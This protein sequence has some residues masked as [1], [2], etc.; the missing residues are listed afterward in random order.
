MNNPLTGL[1]LLD[2]L[3]ELKYEDMPNFD[4][5]KACGYVSFKKDGSECVNFGAFYEAM[6]DAKKFLRRATTGDVE[7]KVGIPVT[8]Y[9]NVAVKGDAGL[10]KESIVRLVNKDHLEDNEDRALWKSI[11]A[12]FYT[13]VVNPWVSG[14]IDSCRVEEIESGAQVS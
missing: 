12:A 13:K 8:V 7:Y 14:Y 5:V 9:V 4:L 3:K 11:K 1:D 6:L 2:K 10:D